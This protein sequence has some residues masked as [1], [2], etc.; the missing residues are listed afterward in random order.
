MG[1]A[2][3]CA[4]ATGALEGAAGLDAG[5]VGDAVTDAAATGALDDAA[6][7]GTGTCAT[8]APELSHVCADEVLELLA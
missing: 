2:G 8:E 5:F 1:A 3:T 4:A 7:L 6:G